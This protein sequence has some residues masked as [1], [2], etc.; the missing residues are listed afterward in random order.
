MQINNVGK[1]ILKPTLECTTA[2]DFS[3]LMATNLESAYHISQLAHPLLKA[4]GYGNIVFI[5][6]VTGVVSCTSSIYGATK[7]SYI[8]DNFDD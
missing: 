1:Y 6:S 2:E 3:S 8:D 5:S 4:S 7:G